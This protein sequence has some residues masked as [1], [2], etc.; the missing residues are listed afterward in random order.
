MD[1]Y[2]RGKLSFTFHFPPISPFFKSLNWGKQ[3]EIGKQKKKKKIDLSY[4]ILFFLPFLFS[5]TK[6]LHHRAIFPFYPIPYICFW[7][8]SLSPSHTNVCVSTM[9]SFRKKTSKGR[10]EWRESKSFK[11]SHWIFP[12][13]FFHLQNSVVQQSLSISTIGV[14]RLLFCIFFFF[15]MVLDHIYSFSLSFLFFL[16]LLIGVLPP[17]STWTSTPL[18][19]C[20]QPFVFSSQE[21]RNP[22]RL[23]L[24]AIETI[25]FFLFLF[26]WV[27]STKK[28]H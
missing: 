14:F 16:C 24:W 25:T 9:N 10:K 12:L 3:T 4:I 11:E 13:P 2:S 20:S 23:R 17:N 8:F 6:I 1:A 7:L 19:V 22:Q 28:K 26:L 5:F 27:K 18:S 15:F 21:K